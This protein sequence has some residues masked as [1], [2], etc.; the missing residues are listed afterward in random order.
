MKEWIAYFTQ[1]AACKKKEICLQYKGYEKQAGE[2]NKYIQNMRKESIQELKGRS[3]HL[4][5]SDLLEEILIIT[6]ASYIVM[7]DFRNSVWPYEY[8]AFARRIGELWEPFCKLPF[9]YPIKKLTIIDP[10]NFKVVQNAIE[11]DAIDY[12][13]SLNLDKNTK[14]ELKRYYSIP[15]TMVDSGGIKLGL[16][17]HRTTPC[18]F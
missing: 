3:E 11:K 17:Q 1:K 2:I 10:P 16:G 13:N 5:Q 6:Y 15:W 9:E 12:I 4:N 7:L 8:M 14:A 18:K